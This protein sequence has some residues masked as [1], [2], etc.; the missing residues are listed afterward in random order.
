MMFPL[1]RSLVPAVLMACLLPGM[2]AAAAGI[3]ITSAVLPQATGTPPQAQPRVLE[4]GVDVV[5][6]ERIATGPSGK[7]H[8][9]FRDGS[10]LTIGAGAEVVLDEFVYDPDSKS[11]QIALSATRGVL[12][13]VGGR[14]SKTNPVQIRTPSATIGIRGGI[15]ILAIG[16]SQVTAKFLF[17]EQLTVVAN[18]Q[19]VTV[20]RPGFQV[21]IPTG[22]NPSVPMPIPPGELDGDLAEL[23]GT[24]GQEGATGGISDND[25]SGSQ[26]GTLGSGNPPTGVGPTDPGQPPTPDIANDPAVTDAIETQNASAG[27][28]MLATITGSSAS[29]TAGAAVQPFASFTFLDGNL[30][31]VVTVTVVVDSTS[32][33]SFTAASLLASGFVDQGGGVFTFTGTEAQA[34]AALQQLV[35]VPA[36]GLVGTGQSQDVSFAI[37]LTDGSTTNAFAQVLT[38]SCTTLCIANLGGQ[39]R[40]GTSTTLGTS[41]SQPIATGS[42]LISGQNFQFTTSAGS[43]SLPVPS[44]SGDFTVSAATLPASFGTGPF[45]GTG[46]LAPNGDFILYE[47]TG[48]QILIFG[49]TPASSFTPGSS[50]QAANYSLRDDFT[51]GGSH[52]PFIPAPLMSNI[53]NPID[54]KMTL[55]LGAQSGGDQFFLAGN[56]QIDGSGSSQGIAGSLLVGLAQNTGTGT[57]FLNGK[58]RGVVDA[59]SAGFA[60]RRF[61]GPV[62]SADDANGFDFFG[63]D[64][65]R[66]TVLEASNVNGSDVN[67]GGNGVGQF[68][69]TGSVGGTI[70]PNVPA[71]N[72]QSGLGTFAPA[73]GS[74]NNQRASQT[75]SG[76]VGGVAVERDSSNNI[77]D[78][79]AFLSNTNPSPS[80]FSQFQITTDAAT[81]RISATMNLVSNLDGFSAGFDTTTII[82]FGGLSDAG[83]SGFLNN[84]TFAAV[85]SSSTQTVNGNSGSVTGFL[86]TKNMVSFTGGV[87]PSGVTL[88]TCNELQ[89]GFLNATLVDPGNA[90][91]D[92]TLA[93]WV[94]GTPA[95]TAQIAGFDGLATYDGHVVAS[96][97]NGSNA[98]VGTA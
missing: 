16:A 41:S 50:F 33:G 55:L 5:A 38:V 71:M 78:V 35:F 22:G 39:V 34:L 85:E 72:T 24:P 57:M 52:I 13:F 43:F 8:L 47:L 97:V 91:Y 86:I 19:T 90:T 49:G 31:G 12:R 63:N 17:G 92:V 14:I 18:G 88:C 64:G 45:S 10:A 20:T 51:L 1:V 4:V 74:A 61:A 83:L 80:V 46:F 58:M 9:L 48:S 29:T 30:D 70:F 28:S 53:V 60:P 25:V 73:A 67:Q 54:A 27:T 77:V 11:G 62:G 6:N 42:T 23:E 76:Y 37:L 2:A 26:L 15:A 95:L 32:S 94:A 81:N 3:G 79:A 59:G 68:Q 75:I 44:T 96:V 89:W 87:I 65:P 93:Q 21:T 84:S 56:V 98:S 40:V 7:T 82:S 69:G 66:Y 36:G